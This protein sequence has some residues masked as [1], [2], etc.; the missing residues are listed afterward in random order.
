MSKRV[1]PRSKGKLSRTRRTTK[2]PG[3][4]KQRP[5]PTVG[6]RKSRSYPHSRPGGRD[7]LDD[8]IDAAAAALDLPIAAD[9]K[10]SIKTNVELTIRVAALFADFPLPDEAEP[11]PIFSA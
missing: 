8:F 4:G 5:R 7:P 10:A 9:W 1:K 6:A 2:R 11:A 3:T